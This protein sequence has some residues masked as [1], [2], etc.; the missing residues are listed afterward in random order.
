MFGVWVL[1]SE[2]KIPRNEGNHEIHEIH[3]IP[4]DKP[5][6]GDRQAVGSETGRRDAGGPTWCSFSGKWL[7]CKGRFPRKCKK[8]CRN[9]SRRRVDGTGVD[10]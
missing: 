9:G 1:M 4:E 2:I 10:C 3:E 5:E 7:I 6:R 8:W